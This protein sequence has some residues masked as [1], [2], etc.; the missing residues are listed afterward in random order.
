MK[1]VFTILPMC[2]VI[3][4]MATAAFA[5][6]VEITIEYENITTTTTIPTTTTTTVPTTTTTQAGGPGWPGGS[7]GTTTTTTIPPPIGPVLTYFMPATLSLYL[8]ETFT[9]R[10]TV[11]NRGDVILHDV[12]V[13]FSGVPNVSFY[14]N[15]E[16]IAVLPVNQSGD[17]MVSM[18]VT[19]ASPG[20][21][22]LSAFIGSREV[23]LT[24]KIILY[25]NPISIQ[26]KQQIEQQKRIEEAK[27]A[28]NVIRIILISII[29]ASVPT[30]G[31]MLYRHLKGKCPLCGGRLE[32]IYKGE[33]IVVYKCKK[34]EREI[35]QESKGEST[36][37][38][39]KNQQSNREGN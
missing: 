39:Q 8:N 36:P 1:I 14:I 18:D 11:V 37:Q 38:M 28:L 34:C 26:E 35:Y 10:I 22:Y 20:T 32:T 31:V 29:A 19:G 21:Y 7:V 25:L 23:N 24:E 27:P 5:A 16:K 30:A 6:V 4:L 9:F 33:N 2:L 12:Y 3:L 13:S 15:P 17:F